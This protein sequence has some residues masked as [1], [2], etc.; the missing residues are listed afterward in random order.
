MSTNLTILQQNVVGQFESED[1]K[2]EFLWASSL[3]DA[4]RFLYRAEAHA[5]GVEQVMTFITS[6][7]SVAAKQHGLDEPPRDL[8]EFIVRRIRN[9]NFGGNR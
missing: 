8:V 2:A 5:R 6:M 7:L 1:A 4:D 9:R 3:N